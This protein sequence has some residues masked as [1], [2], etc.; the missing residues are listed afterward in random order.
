MSLV[1]E[2]YNCMYEIDDAI[3]NYKST[4]ADDPKYL[5]LSLKHRAALKALYPQ[6]YL[7]GIDPRAFDGIEIIKKEEVITL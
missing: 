2:A 6:S 3:A 5:V 7:G 1:E 4:H